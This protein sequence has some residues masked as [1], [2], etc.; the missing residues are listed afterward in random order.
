MGNGDY[1][2]IM[3]GVDEV[4]R[5][6]PVDSERMALIGYSYGGEM[7]GFV[8]GKTTRFKAIV[9]GAPVIVSSVNTGPS[10]APTGTAGI[11]DNRGGTSR[12][13]DDEVLWHTRNMPRRLS[14]CFRD[15]AT[16]RIQKVSPKR[17]T[18]RCG[19]RECQY[20]CF[21]SRAK[22]TVLLEETLRDV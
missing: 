6:S 20:S 13:R 16:P 5:T 22:T 17:C 11:Q 1:L 19:K 15:R 18:A 12:A 8:E 7:A 10:R 9:S 14:C 21:S 4:L 3:T 2:D